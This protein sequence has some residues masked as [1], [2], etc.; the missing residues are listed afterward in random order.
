MASINPGTGG[1][2]TATSA[3]GALQEILSFIRIQEQTA[4]RNPQEK[5]SVNA[6]WDSNSNTLTGTFSFAASRTISG[7]GSINL[8]AQTYL[9]STSYSA[10]SGGTFKSATP[11][12]AA[13]EILEYLQILEANSTANPNNENRITSSF[14]SDRGLYTGS[15]TLP[16][17]LSIGDDGTIV[18]VAPEYLD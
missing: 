2:L 12:S 17:S 10:G 7:D 8:A 6:R 1:T 18:F 15:F 4:G 5:T 13:I 3:E 9:Q 11:E 14:D 16:I